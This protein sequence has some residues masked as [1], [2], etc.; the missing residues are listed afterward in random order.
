MKHKVFYFGIVAAAVLVLAGGLVSCKKSVTS[1]SLNKIMLTLAEGKSEPLIATVL[2]KNANNKSVTWS[3]SD[4]LVASVM[5][6]GLVTAISKGEATIVVTTRD[7]N[8]TASCI[9]TVVEYIPVASVTL[10]KDSLELEIGERETLIA[11]VLPDNA[12]DKTLT[13]KSSN[14]VVATVS[15]G[16]VTAKASGEAVITVSTKEGNKTANCI[17]TVIGRV[18]VESVMLDKDTLVLETGEEDTLI[19]TVLPND[20][21]DKTLTWKSSNPAVASVVNGLVTAKTE[22]ETVVTVTTKDGNKTANCAVTVRNLYIEDPEMVFV[23]GGIFTMGCTF[24]EC[25]D[26]GRE[27]PTHQVTLSSFKIAKCLVTQKQWISIMGKN[28]SQFK[29]DDLPVEMVSWEDVQTFIQ[30]LNIITGK[31]YRLPTEAEWEYAARGGNKSRGYKYS[32]GSDLNTVAWYWGNSGNQTH[33]V[34]TKMAN[35]LEIYDMTGNVWEWCQDRYGS[36]NNSPVTNPQ[37]PN[38]GINRVLRGGCWHSAT[39]FCRISDRTGAIPSYRGNNSGFR[40][41]LDP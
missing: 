19:A 11:T 6:D 21:D 25:W 39:T 29:G 34:G 37:G 31:H 1:V 40:L 9:V 27:L 12:D 14:P 36:Y 38:Y 26:D 8:K 28:P 22:G 33:P 30:K 16:L 41:A 32:G 20:A 2:P 15:N 23:E 18:S 17:V 35:E 4:S 5:P 7:G 10:N 13:W 3:S 24:D